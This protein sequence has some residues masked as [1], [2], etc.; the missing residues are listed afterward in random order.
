VKSGEIVLLHDGSCLQGMQDHRVT[1]ESLPVI[2]DGLRAALRSS[3]WIIS[4][5]QNGFRLG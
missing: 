1:L 5:R 4:R 2:I 3:A